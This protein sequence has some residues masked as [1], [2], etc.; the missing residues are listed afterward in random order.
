MNEVL[1]LLGHVALIGALLLPM[2][3]IPKRWWKARP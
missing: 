1:P 2:I 3:G